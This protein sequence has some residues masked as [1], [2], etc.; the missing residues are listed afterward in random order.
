MAAGL[1]PAA[2]GW[3]EEWIQN[4]LARHRDPGAPFK[5]QRQDGRWILLAEQRL[6]DGSI[7]T[8]SIDIT[9]RKRAE[10]VGRNRA[11][12]FAGSEP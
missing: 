2:K 3:E 6:P 7:A 11:V 10:Q 1:Y 4:R 5:M 9:Q 12:A 8:I